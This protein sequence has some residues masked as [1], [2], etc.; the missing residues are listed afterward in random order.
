[1]IKV[2]EIHGYNS[3]TDVSGRTGAR[4]PVQAKAHAGRWA[5]EG[6]VETSGAAAEGLH[7]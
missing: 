3:W 6:E 7:G 1:M 5:P 2:A 4:H